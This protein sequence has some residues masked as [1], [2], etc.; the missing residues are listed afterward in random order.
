MEKQWEIPRSLHVRN[1]QACA[2]THAHA[3]TLTMGVDIHLYQLI[4]SF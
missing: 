4:S 3:I 1:V 2:E